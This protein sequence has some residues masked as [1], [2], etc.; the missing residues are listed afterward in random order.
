MSPPSLQARREEMEPVR[1]RRVAPE[2]YLRMT[3]GPLAKEIESVR[4]IPPGRRLNDFGQ[5]EV[6]FRS[7]VLVPCA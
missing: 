2:E 4:F 6:T 7:Y 5:F 1:V 3:A